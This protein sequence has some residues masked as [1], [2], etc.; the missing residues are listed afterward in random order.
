VPALV[1]LADVPMKRAVGTSLAVVSLNSISGFAGYMGAVTINYTLM[2]SFAAVTVLASFTGAR[3]ARRL[4]AHTLK[5][6]FAWSLVVATTY[7]MAK[8]VF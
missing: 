7:I 6:A 5:H 2:G 4:H 8:S 1:L 3:L